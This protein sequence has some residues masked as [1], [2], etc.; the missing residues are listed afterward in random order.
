MKKTRTLLF[1]FC[2]FSVVGF[3]QQSSPSMDD[4]FRNPVVEPGKRNIILQNRCGNRMTIMLFEDSTQ[5]EFVYKPN[6]Y[7]R[8]D[9]R[10][11]N[12]SNRDNFT[13]LFPS[14]SLPDIKESYFHRYDYDPFLTKLGLETPNGAKN[15]L[16]FLNIA[17]E[18]AFVVAAKAPLLIA[19]KPH[20]K[21]I[22]KDGLL[23]E[24]FHDRGEDIV[25]YVRFTSY[26]ENRFRRI[27]DGSYILQLFENEVILIGGEENE[28][29]MNRVIK[30][31]DNMKLNELIERNETVLAPKMDK[32][33]LSHKNPDF[34]KVIDI[35]HRIVY[36][37]IDEGGACF[38]ALNRIYHLIWV[39]D[40][41]MTSAL[42]ARAGNPEL[43][44]IWTPFLLENPTYMKDKKGIEHPEFLQLVG[45]R[46]TKSEPDGIY[47]A[48]WSLFTYLQS[49]GKDDLIYSQNF[50]TLISAIDYFLEKNW[51]PEQKMIITDTRGETPLKGNPYFGYDVVNGN[52][53]RND[54]H[55]EDGKV[56]VSSATFYN[57]INTWNV[58]KM[59]QVILGQRP[60]LK[61]RYTTKYSLIAADLK[62]SMLTKFVNP[63]KDIYYRAMYNYTDGSSEWLGVGDNP[64]ELSWAQSLGP[65]FPDINLS[66][67]TSKA[68]KKQWGDLGDYGY[69]PWNCIANKLYEYGMSSSEYEKMLSDEIK[70]ALL[71]TEKY[72]MPGGITEYRGQENNWRALPFSAGSFFFSISGQ[73]LQSLPMGLAVRASDKVDKISNFQYRL[74]KIQASARGSGDVVKSFTLNGEPVRFSLQIPNARLHSGQN[75]IEIVRTT[76]NDAFRL[77]SSSAELL[78]IHLEDESVIYEF[79]NPIESEVIFENFHRKQGIQIIDKQ[80]KLLSHKKESITG[81]NFTLLK[82]P[83]KG[84]FYVIMKF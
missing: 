7:R 54:H 10:S 18:N 51:N 32:G 34:Q 67:N 11:R 27:T 64:W 44:N 43:I 79:S 80:K 4:Y 70:D 2:L 82:I 9:F 58:L 53:E 69:C 55:L 62:S 74:S 68:I 14:F 57:N 50:D 13:L 39:R 40:G 26:E 46:W 25:S 77:Y 35:N 36:S 63:E 65:Y 19:I 24:K 41:T 78:D 17:D 5:L 60:E 16:T 49:T 48:V 52:F 15:K 81:T 56:V 45:T 66:I 31:F 75:T 33:I 30:K 22:E 59:M 29:Q 3:S 42:M 38:G 37:G 61:S 73:I 72:P 47:F 84:K 21:F 71:L 76:E 83:S 12:F 8:K 6:A 28:F 23:L 1:L 20:H